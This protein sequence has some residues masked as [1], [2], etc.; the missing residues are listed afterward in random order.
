MFRKFM[1]GAATLAVVAITGTAQA[2]LLI[3]SSSPGLQVDGSSN[4]D[5]I[6]IAGGLSP[7]TDV[8]VTI[9]FTKCDDPIIGALCAGGGFSFNSEIVFDLT[10]PGGTMVN[11][12]TSGTY[13]GQTPGANVVVTFDDSAAFVVGGG[14]LASGTFQPIGSLA[15]FNGENANGNWTL[16]L[17]DTVGADPL[18]VNS[19]SLAIT[20][21]D[22]PE[23]GTLALFGL[24]LAG[25][26]FARRRKAA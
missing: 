18:K 7:I 24:G 5:M 3:G 8:N 13:S 6:G 4:T 20:T 25:L 14:T 17:Q 1:L 21:R 22:V 11:L 10:S 2:A 9:D 16:F 23:P 12:V 19:W 26:G 15:S